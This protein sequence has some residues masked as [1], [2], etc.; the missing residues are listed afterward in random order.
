MTIKSQAPQ[1][2]HR[3]YEAFVAANGKEPPPLVYADGWFIFGSFIRSRHRAVAIKDMTAR[4]EASCAL[5]V[6]D[7][8][9]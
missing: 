6:K 7:K 2:I 9:E 8:A 4:L 5:I 1:I 3:Y